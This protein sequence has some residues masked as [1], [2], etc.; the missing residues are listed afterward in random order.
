[1]NKRRKLLLALSGAPAATVWKK[2]VVETVL[3]PVH[4]STSGCD[5]VTDGTCSNITDI[6]VE[7]SDPPNDFDRKIA[8]VDS[9]EQNIA[10]GELLINATNLSAGTYRVFGDS[11]GKSRDSILNLG[12]QI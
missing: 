6:T 5:F 11:N 9:N 12:N 10:S 3:L 7:S 2:P 4:A 8:L 1:M